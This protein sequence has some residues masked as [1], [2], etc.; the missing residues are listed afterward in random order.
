[1]E[2]K[3][4]TQIAEASKLA[5]NEMTKPLIIKAVVNSSSVLGVK[6][7]TYKSASEIYISDNWIIAN[8]LEIFIL[9]NIDYSNFSFKNRAY[10]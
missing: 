3:E 2:T 4:I 6:Q 10:K 7:P 1:M 8:S 5:T 9:A